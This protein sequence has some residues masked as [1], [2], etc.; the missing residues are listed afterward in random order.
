LGEK[1]LENNQE[2][3]EVFI[4]DATWFA[5]E[6]RSWRDPSAY[7]RLHAYSWFIQTCG[8]AS[9]D[10]SMTTMWRHRRLQGCW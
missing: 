6:L 7:H 8:A 10:V 9:T 3:V 2:L 5:I 4:G 1:K